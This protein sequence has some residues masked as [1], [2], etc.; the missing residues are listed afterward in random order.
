MKELSKNYSLNQVADI[1]ENNLEQNSSLYKIMKLV[2]N[3]K[4][5]IDFGCATGYLAK[6]LSGKGCYVTG[7]EINQEA[8]KIA[9]QYCQ[10]VITADL[11]SISISKI[12]E[13]QNFDVVVFGDILEHLRNP[14]NIIEEVKPILKPGGYIVASIPNIAHGAIRLALLQ[15][16][17]EYTKY[18]IL[19]DTHIKF[20]TRKTIEELFELSGYFIDTIERTTMPLFSNSSLLPQVTK[21]DFNDQIISYVEQEKEVETL[22]FII[23]AFPASEDGK[24]AS[25]LS[26]YIKL[27]QELKETRAILELIQNSKLWRFKTH[28]LGMI[29]LLFKTS[30][31]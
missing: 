2:G 23:R 1:E 19:D 16:K 28:M 20:F 18:G 31:I 27:Q 3:N 29:N 8:A 14:R 9:E 30:D 24:Y 6:M 25:L 5:V 4:K 17:F 10:R 22:Q 11:D 21:A 15:G 12:V 26:N 7:I 13:D